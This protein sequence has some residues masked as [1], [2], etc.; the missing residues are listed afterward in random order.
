MIH[1]TLMMAAQ[2]VNL[3]ADSDPALQ[4]LVAVIGVL[5]LV[6]NMLRKL[7]DHLIPDKTAKQQLKTQ[8]AMVAQL[9][10]VTSSIDAGLRR[11]EDKI[12]SVAKETRT[13][14]A[15][16]DKALEG[17]ED[18]QREFMPFARMDPSGVP[19]WWCKFPE[20]K[21]D[22]MAR[23]NDFEAKTLA[24]LKVRAVEKQK[25]NQEA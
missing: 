12:D 25:E 13:I 2:A 4:A 5:Y 21:D 24:A 3:P 20:C 16:M 1:E 23:I 11:N 15:G 7:V 10:A 17:V 9:Q 8:E 14:A 19:R 22:I 18:F 6:G